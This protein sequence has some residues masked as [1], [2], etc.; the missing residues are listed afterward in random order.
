MFCFTTWTNT[1][2]DILLYFQMWL[3]N[4]HQER[5]SM[6]SMFNSGKNSKFMKK[7]KNLAEDLLN[8]FGDSDDK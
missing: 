8:N 7:L 5:N 3:K 2:S 4:N 1:E 6:R